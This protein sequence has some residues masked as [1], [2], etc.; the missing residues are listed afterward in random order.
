MTEFVEVPFVDLDPPSSNVRVFF[1]EL[2]ELQASLAA[3]HV[4]EPLIVRRRGERYEVIAGE[5]RYRALAKLAE[6][7]PVPPVPCV[8]RDVAGADLLVLQLAENSGRQRLTLYE[9]GRATIELERL[10]NLNPASGEAAARVGAAIGRSKAHVQAC[11][12]VLRNCAPAIIDALG[13]AGEL[14]DSELSTERLFRW[15]SLTHEQQ[16]EE[17]EA[18]LCNTTSKASPRTVRVRFRVRRKQCE[19][20]LEKVNSLQP[21]NPERWESAR[22]ILRWLLYREPLPAEILPRRRGATPHDPPP[23]TIPAASA[24]GRERPPRRRNRTAKTS[25][26]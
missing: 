24:V 3:E 7:G 25:L 13:R 20:M 14:R 19:A 16:I 23:A 15:S 21:S 11:Q 1:R 26:Q 12:R 4:I 22:L 8:V 18:L 9:I 6:R 10:Q 2:D 17:F 5:R